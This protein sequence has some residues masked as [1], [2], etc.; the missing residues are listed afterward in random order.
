[1]QDLDFSTEPPPN[2]PLYDGDRVRVLPILDEVLNVVYLEGKVKRSGVLFSAG[3]KFQSDLDSGNIPEKLRQVFENNGIS[4]SQNV[5]VSIERTGS[6]WL[7]TD[8]D[9]KKTY[10]VRKDEG[11][12]NIYRF[13][14]YE[15]TPGMKIS[16]LIAK[17]EGVSG[18]AYLPRA[19]L[20]RLNDDE[21]TTTLIPINLA[22]A[23]NNDEVHNIRLNQR[24]RLVV[25]S[26]REVQWIADRIASVQGAV[27]NSGAFERSDNM[28]I[29][30]LL[31][32]AG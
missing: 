8:G 2:P 6:K 26:K 19:D 24:D 11:K 20:F 18:K 4:I 16:D 25:Y 10:S 12:L 22:K 21:K 9:A 32:R 7:I 30:D 28:H 17:A 27:Q 5:T 14:I 31:I 29:S 15:F 13:G 23:L 1:M 3:L